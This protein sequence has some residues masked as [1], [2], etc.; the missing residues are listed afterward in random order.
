M[1]K[2]SVLFVCVK[3]AGKSQ[4]AAGLMRKIAGDTVHVY[5][6]GT[7]PGD[8]INIHPQRPS[9]KSAS[10]SLAK[11]PNPLT[12]NCCATSTLSSFWGERPTLTRFPTRS[13]SAGKPTSPLNAAST[14]SIDCAW[15]AMTSPRASPIFPP[16]SR[17]VR[18]RGGDTQF[19]SPRT[20]GS[21]LLARSLC[22]AGGEG[23]DHLT[24]LRGR[25]QPAR[26][27]RDGHLDVG[28][29]VDTCGEAV[30]NLPDLLPRQGDRTIEC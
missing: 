17:R 30:E 3:N 9:P 7:K 24:E 15:S 13:S 19:K 20:P 29:V 11:R 23:S 6:A 27:P 22:P 26:R 12:P 21:R 5:S 2:P 25:W 18:H 1:T 14:A 8:A 16:E 10:T 28:F 4:M